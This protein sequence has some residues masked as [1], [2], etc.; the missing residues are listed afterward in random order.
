MCTLFKCVPKILRQKSVPSYEMR[1]CTQVRFTCD[2]VCVYLSLPKCSYYMHALKNHDIHSDVT[3][4]LRYY[5]L[6]L[7]CSSSITLCARFRLLL[8]YNYPVVGRIPVSR[9]TDRNNDHYTRTDNQTLL[10]LCF[11]NCKNRSRTLPNVRQ[12]HAHDIA[13]R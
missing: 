7:A 13:Q 12:C 9:V 6:F 5:D 10:I 2:L 8:N 3:F 4:S 11:N 1:K